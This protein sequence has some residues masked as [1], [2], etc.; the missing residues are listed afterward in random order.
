MTTRAQHITPRSAVAAER[1]RAAYRRY[2]MSPEMLR[3]SMQHLQQ[4]MTRQAPPRLPSRPP[5]INGRPALK[6]EIF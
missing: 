2:L 3:Q 5:T 6:G 1:R 4:L